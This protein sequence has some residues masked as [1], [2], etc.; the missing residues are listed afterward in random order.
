MYFPNEELAA[1]NQMIS[2]A[3]LSGKIKFD[4]NTQSV[5]D[6]IAGEIGKRAEYLFD[7]GEEN[8]VV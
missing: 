1:L 3:L 7:T 8:E 6:K 2:I 5:Y 4:K